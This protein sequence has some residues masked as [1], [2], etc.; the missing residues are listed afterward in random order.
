MCSNYGVVIAIFLFSGLNA[1]FKDV[2]LATLNVPSKFE[3]SWID[4]A[5]T[6]VRSWLVDPMGT[7]EHP[8]QGWAIA[9]MALPALGLTVLGYMDQNVSTLIVNRKDHMLQKGPAYHLDLMICGTLFYPIC[10]FFG[11]PFPHAS[12]VPCLIHLIS[13]S[14]RETVHMEGGGTTTRV[15]SVIEGARTTNLLIH[16]LILISLTFTSILKFVPRTVLF[17]VFLFMGV[18]SIAGNELFDRMKLFG[19]WVF[20]DFPSYEYTKKVSVKAMH[21]FTLF[22]MVLLGM[23]YATTRV[24]DLGVAFP[25]FIGALVPLRWVLNRF[26]NPEDLKWLDA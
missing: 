25:F 1:V 20:N 10:S 17:G 15:T 21:S 16:A 23:L 14:N 13:L 18:G 22:Q 6:K 8:I 24:S 7:P 5:T 9:F 12:T 26:W 2:G 11:L 3:P 4:P 19:I